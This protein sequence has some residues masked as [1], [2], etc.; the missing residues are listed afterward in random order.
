MLTQTGAIRL[1]LKV[2]Q[3]LDRGNKALG[4]IKDNMLPNVYLPLQFAE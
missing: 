3:Q 4:F 2:A 1:T